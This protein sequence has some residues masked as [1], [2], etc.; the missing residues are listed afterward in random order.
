MALSEEQ[1]QQGFV[2]LSDDLK[3]WAKDIT[4][5]NTRREALE[6][7]SD[8]ILKE[9]IKN[10]GSG[11]VFDNP[12]GALASNIV[13]QIEMA[14]VNPKGRDTASIGWSN[15]GYYGVFWEHGFYHA[16]G[17]YKGKRAFRGKGQFY[18]KPHIRPAFYA[19]RKEGIAAAI[20]VFEKVMR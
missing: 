7:Y 14:E 12:S 10:A 4:D 2:E 6:A 19:K 8:P 5:Y 11:G 18:K 1:L 15:E 13:R 9:A 20:K 17:K 3:R 16:T